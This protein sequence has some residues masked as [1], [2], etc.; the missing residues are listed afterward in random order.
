VRWIEGIESWI[1]RR[2]AYHDLSELDARMLDDVG[3]S[4]KQVRQL[5]KLPWWP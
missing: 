4:R 5:G 3:I 2:R 1:S